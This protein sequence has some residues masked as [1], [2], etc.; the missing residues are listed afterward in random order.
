M[1]V[2][3]CYCQKCNLELGQFK[4]SWNGIGKAYSSPVY[5]MLTPANGFE[6]VGPV[7]Q[8]SS[9]SLIENSFLQDL[10]CRRCRTSVGLRCDN[11]PQGHMLSRD[12]LI[13]A[14]PKLSVIS[15]ATGDPAKI[16]TLQSFSLTL[17]GLGKPSVSRRAA[18]VQPAVSRKS[19]STAPASN[20]ESS[21]SGSM[22][23]PINQPSFDFSNFKS[24]VHDSITTQQKDIDRVS[25]AL[26]RIEGEIQV[27]REFMKETR[28]ELKKNEQFQT[29]QNA[30]LN[31]VSQIKTEVE[32]LTQK[33]YSLDQLENHRGV[34]GVS[35]SKDIEI[36][37]SDMTK[38]NDKAYE[39]DD[40]KEDLQDVKDQLR[41]AH[42]MAAQN[43]TDL[44]TNKI[45]KTEV[46]DLRDE[47][48]EL[49]TRLKF[50]EHIVETALP[51]Y[52]EEEATQENLN[53]SES[54]VP[55]VEILVRDGEAA[56]PRRNSHS[57]GSSATRPESH[58]SVTGIG[59]DER[60][61]SLK[62]RYQETGDTLLMTQV[63]ST[64]EPSILVKRRKV[65]GIESTR[66][67]SFQDNAR[68]KPPHPEF[69]EIPSSEY[70]G[71]P[72]RNA[73]E[74]ASE[75]TS[76]NY[77]NG[78]ASK[79]ALN[80]TDPSKTN[81][82]E[83][84]T[85]RASLRRVVSANSLTR[86]T[87]T[88]METI[89]D[90]QPG[91]RQS[92]TFDTRRRD[93]NGVLMTPAG[94]MDGRSLR[95]LKKHVT[96][97]E[98]E[99]LP[100]FHETRPGENIFPA[101]LH[102]SPPSSSNSRPIKSSSNN[103]IRSSEKH[104]EHETVLPSIERDEDEIEVLPRFSKAPLASPFPDSFPATSL[105][106]K[107]LE[108]KSMRIPSTVD[109]GSKYVCTGCNRK[110]ATPGGLINHKKHTSCEQRPT[111]NDIGDSQ[112]QK[113]RRAKIAAR[114]RLVQATLEREI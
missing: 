11:A 34:S 64:L 5:P 44:Y 107:Q 47:V 60:F 86:S 13:L 58:S 51:A 112:T 61:K 2:V 114:E 17:D 32:V 53:Q 94:K 102:T 70:D 74:Q 101:N 45:A 92:G 16:S 97:G 62:R 100:N 88:E 65:S 57:L 25:G 28:I 110:Y 22:L 78:L 80:D 109:S 98:I 79:I 55:K 27:F 1:E 49:K 21:V 7:F 83:R 50:I 103:C 37:I 105:P 30:D 40:V 99:T 59:A 54:L 75:L 84:R 9:R 73:L 3:V 82:P 56:R 39:V 10:V 91:R 95:R 67:S 12:Q 85:R 69:I 66:P 8:G 24:W 46:N 18:T 96:S 87:A 41:I 104:I 111:H 15:N 52:S 68:L 26:N 35:L 71:S 72:D 33:V 19:M 43:S 48:K 108:I 106:T 90:L 81:L 93:S 42:D 36:I 31:T 29:S 4:N 38:V 14:L 77:L 76:T 20:G 23:P 6:A 113:N 63:D 89:P